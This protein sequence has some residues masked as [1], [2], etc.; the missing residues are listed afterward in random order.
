M[1]KII[2]QHRRQNARSAIG[3][4]SHNLPACR[5]FFVHSHRIERHPVVDHMRGRH[6]QPPFGDQRIMDA[7]GPAAHFQAAGQNP[8]ALHPARDAV[9]HDLPKARNALVDVGLRPKLQLVGQ[10]HLGNRQ[11]R[12]RGHLHHLVGRFERIGHISAGFGFRPTRFDLFGGCQNKAAADGVIG[13]LQDHIALRISSLQNHAIGMA[14]QGG[15]VI[16]HQV[17]LGVKGQL[18]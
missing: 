11:P 2:A 12:F 4:G 9:V 16:E 15:A 14:G 1:I 5:V 3:R 7:L 10:F 17:F 13:F 8:C 6:I 18:A